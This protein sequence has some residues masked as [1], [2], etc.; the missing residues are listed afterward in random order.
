LIV[1]LHTFLFL[2]VFASATIAVAQTP[3]AVAPV[4]S[5]PLELATGPTKVL[6]TPQDRSAILELVERARQNF[7]M[8][9]AATPPYRLKVSFE[10]GGRVAYTGSGE[11]EEIWLSPRQWRW[12]AHL[13]GYSQ[14]RI[15]YNGRIYDDKPLTGIPMRVQM[16]RGTLLWP[17]TG[18]RPH[19]LMKA[20]PANWKGIE[21][22][23]ALF[24][25]AGNAP[26]ATT[27]RQ[28][29][30]YEYCFDPKNSL[31]MTYSEAPGIYVSYDYS[32]ALSFHGRLIPAAVNFVEGGSTVLT[33]HI[34]SLT[35]A[36]AVDPALMTPTPQMV[37][38][39]PILAG[40]YRIPRA[41]AAPTSYKGPIQ[42]VIVHATVGQDGK[43]LEAEALQ[44][45]DTLLSDSAV[46]LV[47]NENWQSGES[48]NPLQRELFVNVQ[49]LPPQ[50]LPGRQ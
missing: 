6:N 50:L 23:C 37:T 31:L 19:A 39:G 34:D 48:R 35:D 14:T 3:L 20:T 30:E 2:A 1:R 13:A 33:I 46:D 40:R 41:M 47:R 4:P 28:W 18:P 15:S 42:P 25:G 32:N 44:T 22:M 21:V 7:D 36:G 8:Q 11:M 10:A 43:V 24:S 16:V 5:D 29:Q 45:S 49:F 17:I 26:M 9:A 27:G 12:A 38:P